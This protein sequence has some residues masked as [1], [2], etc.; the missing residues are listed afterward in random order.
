MGTTK[1]GNV[2]DDVVARIRTWILNSELAPGSRL[3]QSSLAARLGVSRIPVRDALRRLAAEGLVDVSTVGSPTVAALSV[4]DLQELY[5][6]REAVEPIACRLAVPNVG[7]AQL[8]TMSECLAAMEDQGNNDEW[9]RAH[10]RF[11]VQIYGQS[12]RPR[13]IALVENLRQQAERYL[14]LHLSSRESEHL[15]AEHHEL[16]RAAANADAGLVETLTLA[17]LRTSHDSILNHLLREAP[18]GNATSGQVAAAVAGGA[19]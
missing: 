7:R 19:R 1:A 16:L 15:R 4:D 8:L 14:R 9:L 17:H 12:R 18:R 3:N 2:A 11:H 10:V 13:M 5:E 6:L